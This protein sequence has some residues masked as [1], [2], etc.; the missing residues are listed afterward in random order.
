M[1][2]RY[3]I[4]ALMALQ[5]NAR[6]CLQDAATRPKDAHL[7]THETEELMADAGGLGWTPF[8]EWWSGYLNRVQC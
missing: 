1:N 2:L 5:T 3:G 6:H 8:E 7:Y 4:V